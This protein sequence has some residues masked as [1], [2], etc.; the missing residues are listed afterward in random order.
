MKTITPKLLASYYKLKAY[1]YDL[2]EKEKR[3]DG[4]DD[5]YNEL[6]KKY[7]NFREKAMKDKSRKLPTRI[8]DTETQTI[9]TYDQS[10]AHKFV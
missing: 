6:L 3:D 5:R 4:L 2:M 10:N 7:D 1:H 8:V 9:K